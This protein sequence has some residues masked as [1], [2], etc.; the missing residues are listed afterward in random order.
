MTTVVA[1]VKDPCDVQNIK[2]LRVDVYLAADTVVLLGTMYDNYA[3]DAFC[4]E[5]RADG[6]I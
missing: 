4:L 3:H 2:G 6:W 5:G 1:S